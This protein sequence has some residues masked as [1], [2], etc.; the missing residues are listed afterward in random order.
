MTLPDNP[1]PLTQP[2]LL[3]LERF[4]RS[5]DSGDGA[6]TLSHAHGFLTAIVSGPESFE[7]EEWIRLIFDEP[8]FSDAAQVQ[9]ILGL[10]VRL[11]ASIE[12][13]LPVPGSFLPIFEYVE[14]GGGGTVYRAEQWCAGF[15]SAMALWTEPLS[16]TLRNTL[17]PLFL[18]ASPQN[19]A[20]HALQAAH[21]EELCALL[22][23]M[24]EAI[25]RHW[26]G[27]PGQDSPQ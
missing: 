8:V 12:A 19:R 24:A 11:H 20:Q 17:E 25:Y 1:A 26:H 15:I 9:D 18:I 14:A 6:M 22:P 23:P 2:E 7:A 3:R 13:A 21:Y 16:R 4:L 27:K 10:I 5:G